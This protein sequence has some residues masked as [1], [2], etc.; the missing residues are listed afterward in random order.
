[1]QSNVR[2]SD[3]DRRIFNILSGFK[4]LVIVLTLLYAASPIQAQEKIKIFNV[5]VMGN[6]AASANVIIR[7]SGLVAGKSISGDD[8]KSAVSRLWAMK[9]FSNI[10]ISIEKQ[11]SEGL[12]LLITVEEYPKIDKY[13]LK[14]N[15]N[16]KDD[17]LDDAVTFFMGQRITPH[18]EIRTIRAIKE[19]YYEKG[20]L[21]VEISTEH[22]P[23]EKEDYVIVRFNI[24][25]GSKVKIR[26]I[27]FIGAENF[28]EGDLKKQLKNTKEKG[29]IRFW[30]SGNFDREEYEEDKK[31]L[32]QFYRNNGF[33]DAEIL[34]DSLYYGEKREKL[35]LDIT[36]REG[37][38]YKLG[39]LT[40]KDNKLFTEDELKVTLGLKEGDDYNA[41][42]I[43]IAVYDK[44][45]GIYMDRGNLFVSIDPKQNPV[46]DDVVDIEFIIKE[47]QKV[48]VRNINIY[49]NTKTKEKVIRREMKIFP[50]DV[51]SRSKLMRS[52]REIFILN[53]FANVIPNIRPVD[54]DEI[55]IE[56]SVE[57]KQTDRANASAGFSQRDGA[58]G[59][60]GVDFNNFIGNGQVLSFNW[61]FGSVF[62]SFSI[63]FTEPWLFDTP[64][65]A[66]FRVFSTKRKG[67][68]FPLDQSEIGG[69][70]NLGR[71]FRWPDDYFRGNASFRFAQRKFDNISDRGI[72]EQLVAPSKSAGISDED[73][74]DVV[75][76]TQQRRLTFALTRD[77]RDRPEF[78]T[79]GSVFTIISQLSGGP[80]GGDE[81][82]F[83][84]IF[85]LDWY[86]PLF[87]KFVLLN[88]Y[89]Y[90]A[91]RT[92]SKDAFIPFDEFF[93]MGGSGLTIGEPLRGYE[94]RTVGPPSPTSN[95]FALGGRVLSKFSMELRFPIAPNPV[96]FGLFFYEGGNTWLNIKSANIFDLRRSAG[97]G[98]RMFM[99]LVGLIGFDLGYG[100]DDLS[101]EGEREGWEVHF[102]F[103]RQ[104]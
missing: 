34:K 17:K 98:L 33:R 47:N 37:K 51:F 78:P 46:G 11:V 27:K 36:V 15:K 90:G 99:P 58:I 68:F 44:L 40:F 20:Y 89:K 81:N 100:F 31:N 102:Q 16:L 13:E 74:G 32:L 4:L 97:F 43:D 67:I 79:Q 87:W 63:G 35:Y 28:S 59:S 14:G 12:F 82:F 86:T 7:N 8:I 96:I 91:I 9:I 42:N 70:L 57:E 56:L 22:I 38:R 73:I 103:G 10:Q 76:E 101:V 29:T 39:K 1:M 2:I 85:S 93:F 49:G 65:L 41:A 53:Y 25:E 6:K 75:I 55:D 77:S 95:T 21:L 83:K 61:Q 66:G 80:I 30:R 92:F 23:S 26:G 94:D 69:S 19:L 24:D 84:S 88:K 18:M 48:F 45:N 72:L 64:T 71:R 52:Q 62:R 54:D 104:F 60:I 5:D 3:T 50:G